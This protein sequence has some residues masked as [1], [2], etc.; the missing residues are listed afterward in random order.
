MTLSE[1]KNQV[2]FQTN[3]DN[4][5]VG[6][7]LPALT[8]YINEAYDRLVNV[9]AK[10]HVSSDSTDWPALR[11]YAA[12]EPATDPPVDVPRTPE[13]THRYLADWATWLVYRNGNPQKQQR[14]YAYRESFLG[15]LAKISDEGGAEGLNEDGTQKR[16]R[17]FFNIPR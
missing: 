10:Q 5:D 4:E 14:G 2:M 7:F 3:N 1:I 17:N 13:W 15:M 8:D 6:D 12:Q 9:W 11:E 16:F